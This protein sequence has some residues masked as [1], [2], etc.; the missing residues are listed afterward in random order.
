MIGVMLLSSDGFYADTVGSVSW[1]PNSDKQWL[2]NLIKDQEVLVGHNT[3]VSISMF[4]KLMKLATWVDKPTKR[5]TIN[6]GGLKTWKKYPPDIF[7]VHKTYKPLHSGF[8][9]AD[10]F[11]DGYLRVTS[12][13]E[14]YYE[15]IVYGKK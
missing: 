9:L 13:K 3:F 1:G 4:P 14:T 10:N 6:F 12:Y 2:H 15:E 7:I 5:T 11:F 8:K